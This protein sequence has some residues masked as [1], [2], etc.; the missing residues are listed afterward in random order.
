M[1]SEI[2]SLATVL[3]RFG[4]FLRWQGEVFYV[5]DAGAAV[6]DDEE[7][8]VVV[9]KRHAPVTL[10]EA[11]MD[12]D[13]NDIVA[14]T[15]EGFLQGVVHHPRPSGEARRV[16]GWIKRSCL[17]DEDDLDRMAREGP[18]PFE[19]WRKLASALR[20]D[21]P[22]K[23]RLFSDKAQ[24][25]ERSSGRQKLLD[26]ALDRVGYHAAVYY[27][28]RIE[29]FD[30]IREVGSVR[31]EL[32]ARKD[33]DA[34]LKARVERHG[35]FLIEVRTILGDPT[36]K[37]YA[38]QRG[39]AVDVDHLRWLVSRFD[40][41]TEDGKRGMFYDSRVREALDLRLIAAETV[42]DLYVDRD[43]RDDKKVF[44][45]HIEATDEVDGHYFR[46][47]KSRGKDRDDKFDLHHFHEDRC[48]YRNAR[49][50]TF[51]IVYSFQSK[52]WLLGKHL[53]D[54]NPVV[55]A[56]LNAIASGKEAA[57]PDPPPKKI[58]YAMSTSLSGPWRSSEERKIEAR[59]KVV[60]VAHFCE[61]RRQEGLI[62]HRRFLEKKIPEDA[63]EAEAAFTEA[64]ALFR[65]EGAPPVDLKVAVFLN[66]A[67]TRADCFGDFRLALTDV[68][69]AE[70]HINKT[71][72]DLVPLHRETV[73]HAPQAIE[74][75]YPQ[76]RAFVSVGKARLLL[77]LGDL[78]AAQDCLKVATR[79]S[80][81]CQQH[82]IRQRL[83][84]VKNLIAHF[85]HTEQSLPLRGALLFPSSPSLTA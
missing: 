20:T 60:T 38:E 51:F 44:S 17:R 34:T 2:P 48:V 33:V 50:T 22:V 7:R 18:G 49:D 41:S 46:I 62:Y 35:L 25:Y 74:E 77:H 36:D 81:H 58:I 67:E 28:S 10:V 79:L 29:Q 8:V 52:T 63:S 3:G 71:T 66:R 85:K 64:I 13:G 76:S 27:A 70:G 14:P 84:T 30:D 32:R 78:A 68:K 15:K 53:Y 19:L 40:G 26:L 47:V 21:N 12:G 4:S 83:T 61:A 45:V 65:A 9:L 59:A 11:G 37:S 43:C 56:D 69:K 24:R 54:P 82:D 73:E 23:L 57:A 72:K 42:S 31:D 1:A 5:V 75:Q 6:Y 16:V 80:G 55:G 39:F